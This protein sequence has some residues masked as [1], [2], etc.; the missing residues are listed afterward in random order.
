MHLHFFDIFRSTADLESA[1]RRYTLSN[2]LRSRPGGLGREI[3]L[4]TFLETSDPALSN[5]EN[6]LPIRARVPEI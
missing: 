5:G 2:F 3:F 1:I 4:T 6:R